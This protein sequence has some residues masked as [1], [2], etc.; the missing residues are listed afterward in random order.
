MVYTRMV[1]IPVFDPTKIAIRIRGGGLLPL[2]GEVRSLDKLLCTR[3]PGAQDVLLRDGYLYPLHRRMTAL[4]RRIASDLES[5]EAAAD[6][7]ARW[8]YLH[9]AELAAALS[10]EIPAPTAD[11]DG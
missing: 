3:S 5:R 7:L 2:L 4:C 8:L 1:R 6:T 10:D 9:N 11:T